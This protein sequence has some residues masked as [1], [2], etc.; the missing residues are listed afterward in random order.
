M[1]SFPDVASYTI[2]SAKNYSNME[3]SRVLM[4]CSYCQPSPGPCTLY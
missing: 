3:L 4:H 1:H 2:N